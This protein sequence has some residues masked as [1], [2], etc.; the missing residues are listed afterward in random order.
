VSIH[1][2]FRDEKSDNVLIKNLV[3]RVGV[4][5]GIRIFEDLFDIAAGVFENIF[6]TA[7][8]ILNEIGDIVDLVADGDVA[9]VTRVMRFD[10]SASE[11]W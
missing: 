2:L 9:R 3:G 8:V 6:G 4:C 7:R 11:S 10:L 1:C 5:M